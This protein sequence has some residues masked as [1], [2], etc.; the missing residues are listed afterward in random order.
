MDEL[1][2]LHEQ[3]KIKQKQR[4]QLD[5]K[6]L[7]NQQEEMA[8]AIMRQVGA[9]KLLRRVQAALLDGQGIIEVFEK[10]DDF[11]R[12]ISLVWQG[13]I[14]KAR[15]PDPNSSAAYSYIFIGVRR[16]K[17]YVNNEQLPSLTP[18]ALKAALVAAAKNPGWANG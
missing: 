11:D 5:P 17:L 3:D 18:E 10:K 8:A 9:L 4:Q 14:S 7:A 16:G 6:V 2:E 15:R 12:L 13:P 1:Y